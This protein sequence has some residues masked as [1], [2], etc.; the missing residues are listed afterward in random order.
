M[1]S[2]FFKGEIVTD[3]ARKNDKAPL[4]FRLKVWANN[5]KTFISIVAWGKVAEIMEKK[6]LKKGNRVFIQ[7]SVNSDKKTYDVKDESGKKIVI[8]SGPLTVTKELVE[9]KA[10]SIEILL[11]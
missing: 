6:G 3:P 7:A 9:F 8:G 11:D 5:H 2:C 1:N 10:H 4:K